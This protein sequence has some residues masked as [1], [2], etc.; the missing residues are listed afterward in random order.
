MLFQP[1]NYWIYLS[2]Q[3]MCRYRDDYLNRGLAPESELLSFASPKESNQRKVDPVAALILRCYENHPWFSP[4]GP[5]DGC[6]NLLQANLSLSTEVDERDSCPFA[7]MRHPCRNPHGLLTRHIP[8]PRP[9]GAMHANR[10]SC[11][12]V[13]P[14]TPVLSAA[15]GIES[16][17]PANFLRSN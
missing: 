16:V 15:Y 12:F 11:R 5:A 6:S 13:P 8:V 3:M 2:L 1:N 17:P 14:K 7:N 4:C 9:L 10:L